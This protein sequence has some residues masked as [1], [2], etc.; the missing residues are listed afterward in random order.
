MN[1]ATI[2]VQFYTL[3]SQVTQ[4]SQ[5]FEATVSHLQIILGLDSQ[6]LEFRMSWT[7]ISHAMLE[8]CLSNLQR[9]NGGTFVQHIAEQLDVYSDV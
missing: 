7:E 4:V 1:Q 8:G 5:L 9:L 3:Q 2:V 6:F